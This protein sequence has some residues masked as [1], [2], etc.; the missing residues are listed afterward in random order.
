MAVANHEWEKARSCSDEERKERDLYQSLTEKHNIGNPIATVDEEVIEEVVQR[1]VGGQNL[2]VKQ[3][4][5]RA[6]LPRPATLEKGGPE[7]SKENQQIKVFLCHSSSDKPAVRELYKFLKDEGFDPWLDEEALLPGQ[8][9]DL[10]VSS[11][12]RS[13]QVVVVCLSVGSVT[14]AGYVQKE[15]RKVLDVADEQPEGTIYV[16]PL[17]LEECDVPNRLRRWQWVNMFD[18]RGSERL[19]LALRARART[20]QKAR[21]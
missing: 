14:K 3:D 11:A 19:I 13:C 6:E 7:Y 8:E 18:A 15:I 20:L 16:I 10:E 4:E 9:W 2:A 21:E 5:R 1:W 17:K 12:V